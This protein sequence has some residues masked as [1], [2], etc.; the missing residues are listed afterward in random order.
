M[1]QPTQTSDTAPAAFGVSS[2][3]SHAAI[4]GRFQTEEESARSL[5][6]KPAYL[7]RGSFNR[8]E[9]QGT[10]SAFRWRL[11]ANTTSTLQFYRAR[12]LTRRPRSDVTDHFRQRGGNDVLSCEAVRSRCFVRIDACFVFC[13]FLHARL[14]SPV[15]LNPPSVLQLAECGQ[16][17]GRRSELQFERR[18]VIHV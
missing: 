12:I 7:P 17:P 8:F 9:D 2:E 1:D 6:W 3:H 16:K 13:G 14:V 15:P 18:C 5:L 10:H 11:N 4:S